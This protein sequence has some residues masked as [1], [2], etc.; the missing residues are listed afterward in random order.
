MI[1]PT[2][3][4]F[5]LVLGGGCASSPTID[6][7][8]SG[9]KTIDYSDGISKKEAILIAQN[10]MLVGKPAETLDR[11]EFPKHSYLKSTN[12]AYEVQFQ[13]KGFLN[14]WFWAISIDKKTGKVLEVVETFSK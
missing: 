9:L 2:L 6:S 12:E 11:Y 1:K 3:L 13:A 5:L 14:P 10:Q 8:K 7:L 4:P